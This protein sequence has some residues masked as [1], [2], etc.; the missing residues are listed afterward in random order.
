MTDPR[1]LRSREPERAPPT[2]QPAEACLTLV[3]R[4][5][6]FLKD[7]RGW[8]TS[9]VGRSHARA[10]PLPP[11]VRGALRAAYGHHL[12]AR[13]VPRFRRDDWE[14]RTREVQLRQ[15]LTVRRPMIDGVDEFALAHRLWP[16][17]HDAAIDEG[18][19]VVQLIPSP[20]P[21]GSGLDLDEV[22]EK[23]ETDGFDKRGG[24]GGDGS[25]HE[26]AVD[27]DRAAFQRLWRVRPESGRKPG[28]RP[29]FW[30]EA[31]MCAWLAGAGVG[32]ESAGGFGRDPVQR[33]DIHVTITPGTD[34]AT[35]SMM[36]WS[37]VTEPIDAD[38]HEWA[39]AVRC[40][41]PGDPEAGGFPSGPIGLGGRRRQVWAEPVDEA[42][43]AMPAGLAERM[44]GSRGLRLLC[45]TPG[46]FARGW[47]PDGFD[48]GPDGYVGRLSGIGAE[49]CLRAAI[50]PRPLHLSTWDTVARAPRATLR[51]VA[52]GSVYFFTKR[53]GGE[54]TAREY[55]TLWLSAVGG[56]VGDGLGLVVPGRWDAPTESASSEEASC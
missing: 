44:A 4:D 3:A 1:S 37:Q 52:P 48:A 17:P 29:R 10:W 36:F 18:G 42:L 45:V 8:Y 15:V 35:P 40:G 39:L 11:T 22:D 41:L 43:F 2:A 56:G 26:T 47:L 33:A 23:G 30:T 32:D 19:A 27:R 12:M 14:P 25:L 16:T 5:G 51:L 54:F 50:V 46:L 20:A 24:D 7:G 21:I 6:L 13:G 55:Q 49:L 53:D 28:P 38:G 34:A 31:A 9:D